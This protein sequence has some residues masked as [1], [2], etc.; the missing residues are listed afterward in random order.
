MSIYKKYFFFIFF[1]AHSLAGYS[2]TLHSIIVTDTAADTLALAAGIS[3]KKMVNQVTNIANQTSLALNLIVILG[4]NLND[5]TI[6]D[7]ILNLEVN[8]DDIIVFFW[9]GHGYNT[10][11]KSQKSIWPYLYLTNQRVGIDFEEITQL[12]QQKNP[13]F[14]L[15]IADTCNEIILFPPPLKKYNP[16][17]DAIGILN[18]TKGY[19]ELFLNQKGS[20][21]ISSSIVD[22]YA[23]G[24]DKTGSLFTNAFLHKFNE[25]LHKGPYASWESILNKVHTHLEQRNQIPQWQRL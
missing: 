10:L 5:K 7:A 19:Q 14:L 6:F 13:Q 4:E 8:P 9:N 20:L 2:A 21:I 15:A 11:T 1:L 22:T 12:L 23:Y 18:S 17:F 16:C 24:N 25:E 3:Q